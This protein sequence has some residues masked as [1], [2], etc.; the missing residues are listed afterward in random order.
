[1]PAWTKVVSSRS[2]RTERDVERQKRTTNRIDHTRSFASSSTRTTPEHREG[3]RVGR[4]SIFAGKLLAISRREN[5][6]TPP[7]V[8]GDERDRENSPNDSVSSVSRVERRARAPRNGKASRGEERSTR[9]SQERNVPDEITRLGCTMGEKGIVSLRL[10]RETTPLKNLSGPGKKVEEEWPG[11]RNWGDFR[12]RF[13]DAFSFF[14][15]SNGII[16]I[17]LE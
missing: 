2:E 3:A 11:K 16:T 12:E 13:R 4:L 10:P 15:I 1:M 6:K 9:N 17:F 8:V 7:A 5:R 14:D